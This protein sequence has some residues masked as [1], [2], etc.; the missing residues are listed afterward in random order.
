M[1]RDKRQYITLPIDFDEHPKVAL[2]SDS[3]FRTFVEMNLYS[4]RNELDGVIPFGIA[5]KRWNRKALNELEASHLDR[6]L[7]RFDG[8]EYTIRDY[9]EHQLTRA[10]VEAIRSRN[11]ENGK[12]GG[13]PKKTQSVSS[14]LATGLR[15]QNPNE[16]QT[17][18]ESES[19]SDLEKKTD[20]TN[21]TQV[22]QE[23]YVAGVSTDSEIAS[24]AK[25]AGIRNLEQL[26]TA[27]SRCCGP[28]SAKGAIEL[29]QTI[30][31]RAKRDVTKV[32][33]Y[34]LTAI[35]NT[36]DEVRW[37]YERLDLGAIA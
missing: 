34:V 19:E 3:A 10:D 8:S 33:G 13:R 27:F 6:P 32:D 36:P 23:R 2:L 31:S 1:P 7:I 25:F 24:L 15:N 20:M 26:Q 17:K 5:I 22:S 29:A 28:I 16:T 35:Q 14:G 4:R 18:A 9:A 37:D 21:D 11:T 30:C 12:R